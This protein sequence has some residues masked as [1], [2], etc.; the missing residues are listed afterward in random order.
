MTQRVTNNFPLVAAVTTMLHNTV[1]LL[2]DVDLWLS[3]TPFSPFLFSALIVWATAPLGL[4]ISGYVLW[5]GKSRAKDWVT[6]VFLL[7]GIVEFAIPLRYDL[8]KPQSALSYYLRKGRV[9]QARV[10]EFLSKTPEA[11]D[12]LNTAS[13]LRNPTIL[14]IIDGLFFSKPT[15]ADVSGQGDK[16][17]VSITFGGGFGHWGLE[18]GPPEYCTSDKVWA[19]QKLWDGVYC[20]HD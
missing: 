15:Y 5:K 14:S 2:F 13:D 20:F 3:A 11:T 10:V 12:Q 9:L 4:M 1:V 17:H 19:Y 16:R 7:A 18:V 8:P 6:L